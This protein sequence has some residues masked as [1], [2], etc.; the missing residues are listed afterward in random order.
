[1]IL[2]IPLMLIKAV[3]AAVAFAPVTTRFA[4]EAEATCEVPALALVGRTVD[5]SKERPP[6][7]TLLSVADP[8]YPI[9]RV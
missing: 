8:P 2:T 1:L 9:P 4:A 5:P 7:N 3:T 6:H